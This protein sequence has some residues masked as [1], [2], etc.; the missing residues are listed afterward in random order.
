MVSQANARRFAHEYPA[1]AATVIES[2]YM[3][4]SM[5]SVG[6]EEEGIELY[7]QLSQLWLKA[8]MYAR[9]WISNSVTVLENIPARD[10]A[11][12]IN[13]ETETEQ[14]VLH[15]FV[16][17]SEEAYSAVT[18]VRRKN[19][20]DERITTCGLKD[21]KKKQQ[22]DDTEK[23]Q[24]Y[25]AKSTDSYLIQDEYQIND[26]LEP[27]HFSS[28][29]RMLRV[30]AWV[31]RFITNG[32]TK[33]QSESDILT[34]VE[35][36]RAEN[37]Y[38]L[39]AQK[40]AFP[41][42]YSA[43]LSE[44]PLPSRSKVVSLNA[45]LDEN[46]LIRSNTRLQFSKELPFNTMCPVA[47]PRRHPV[48]KL[49]VKHF[50]EQNGHCGT[51]QTLAALSTRYWLI[52][53]REEIREVEKDCRKCRLLKSRISQQIMAPLPKQRTEKTLRA[54]AYTSVDY[55]GPFLTKQGRGKSRQKRYLCLFTCLSSRAVH[56]EMATNLDTVSFLNAFCRFKS[57]R[58][59]PKE[60][61]SDNGTN[62]VGA[63]RELKELYGQID[64]DK[65]KAKTADQSMKWHFNPPSA[66]HFEGIHEIII[67]SAKRAV[68]RIL[69]GADVTDEELQTAFIE[70]KGLINSRPLSYQISNPSDNTVLTPNHFLHGQLGGEFALK[71][72]TTSYMITRKDGTEYKK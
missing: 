12:E 56:L 67:K 60:M 62:F 43:L 51:N 31:N 30:F 6:S 53:G 52:S 61:F 25:Q 18:Y 14:T 15:T 29:T 40:E 65:V 9:K 71:Q 47:L 5:D 19:Q 1:A 27:K 63:R 21:L 16:D 48:T 59:V 44:K 13:L 49:I 24:K 54:F 20:N 66:P 4:D 42:E 34:Y 50:H 72:Q 2:T 36:N 23:K 26:R 32:R 38:I 45:V 17:A 58:G 55:G 68:Y 57:R 37:R 39:Y 3:D 22:C 11:A 33:K 35:L 28:W 7:H 10:R 41:N 69:S 64:K 46:R 70:A 8:E